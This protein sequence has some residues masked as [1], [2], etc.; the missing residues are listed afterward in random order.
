MIV[1]GSMFQPRHSHLLALATNFGLS[2]FKTLIVFLIAWSSFATIASASC[3]TVL[4]R[5]FRGSELLINAEMLSDPEV[6]SFLNNPLAERGNK[7]RSER[8]GFR[9]YKWLQRDSIYSHFVKEF[10]R[11]FSR[12]SRSPFARREFSGKPLLL[13]GRGASESER[14]QSRWSLEEAVGNQADTPFSR[15]ELKERLIR[16][17]INENVNLSVYLNE[18]LE[19]IPQ[20]RPD[21]SHELNQLAFE[22]LESVHG[23]KLIAGVDGPSSGVYQPSVHAIR[24]SAENFLTDDIRSHLIFNHELVHAKN[25]I[26]RLK[27]QII[28]FS[29]ESAD[30]P[31]YD[32]YRNFQSFDESEAF[33]ASAKY[34]LLEMF[35]RAENVDEEAIGTV[36]RQLHPLHGLSLRSE[37]ILKKMASDFPFLDVDDLGSVEISQG[38]FDQR[39]TAVS[40]GNRWVFVDFHI[41]KGAT[42]SDFYHL[43]PDLLADS[44]SEAR[45]YRAVASVATAG[46]FLLSDVESSHQRRAVLEGL[47]AL[48]DS[49]IRSQ[50]SM[51][52]LSEDGLIELYNLKVTESLNKLS[53]SEPGSGLF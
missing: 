7:A 17:L 9:S 41:P 30:L 16:F 2:R 27:I 4:N 18:K 6:A 37:I 14:Q 8:P 24:L 49:D 5:E 31:Y 34:A 42:R 53:Q 43:T 48:F 28:F 36:F 35:R 10:F 19:I 22:L 15:R 44:I 25:M 26:D 40:I 33:A 1:S 21:G 52:Q 20:I 39:R 46:L 38:A 12:L 51:R 50:D 23:L 13:D 11:D 45:F 47:L 32:F 3:N 29:S